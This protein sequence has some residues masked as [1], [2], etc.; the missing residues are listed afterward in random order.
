MH[1][2]MFVKF[3]PMFAMVLLLGVVTSSCKV[4]ASSSWHWLC[5]SN[6]ARASACRRAV[7]SCFVSKLFGFDA[8]GSAMCLHDG[9]YCYCQRGHSMACCNVSMK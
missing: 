5:F 7:W 8:H 1:G 9:C 6:K 2:D 3:D 4:R